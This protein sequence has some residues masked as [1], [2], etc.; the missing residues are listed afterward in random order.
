MSEL[1][2]TYYTYI[3]KAWKDDNM[4][5][6]NIALVHDALK[7]CYSIQICY[8]CEK[9]FNRYKKMFEYNKNYFADMLNKTQ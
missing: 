3:Q 8:Y 2:A 4:D 7:V 1:K 5:N 9:N 6:E